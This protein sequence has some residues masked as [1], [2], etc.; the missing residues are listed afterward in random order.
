MV[1]KLYLYISMKVQRKF[2][3]WVVA[4]SLL[5]FHISN[6][7][8]V[9]AQKI[10]EKDKARVMTEG[11]ALY[12][13]I[14]ANWTSNDLYYENE[15]NTNIV[16]GYLSYRDKDTLKTI[17]WRQI[18]T[19]SVEYKAK[20][21]KAADDTVAAEQSAKEVELNRVVKT[22]KYNNMSVSKKN[23]R[24]A[25]EEERVPASYEKMLIDYR[26]RAYK[27]IST[28]TSFFKLY[29]GTKLRAVP[30]DA[31]KE[32][33]IFI[34][35]SVV[36]E[37]IVPI[38]SDYL[39]VYDK[40]ENVLVSKEDF[41]KDC[42]FISVQ[43]HGR[44]SDASKSTMHRHKAGTSPLITPTDIATLLLYKS[45]LEWD[46]HHVVSDKYTSIFTLIDKKLDIMLTKDFEALKAKK[47]EKENEAKKYQP[48]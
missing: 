23:A 42:L 16:K 40:K 38:G 5:I 44:K 17:F 41:H 9:S 43:Y 27:E 30:I 20:T 45:H 11:L 24:I 32:M 10:S 22:V 12:T 18:D 34:Y 14:L 3:G 36:K 21:Y 28:D 35:P 29:S 39:L 37:G 1:W 8:F 6:L 31:G 33:K 7:T 48:H 4:C 25:D 19:T 47:L 15:F 2:L 13:L 26:D 46:E